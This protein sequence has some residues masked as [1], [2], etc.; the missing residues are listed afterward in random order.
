MPAVTVS[1]VAAIELPPTLSRP[2]FSL[3]TVL[4]FP[5][6]PGMMF[7]AIDSEPPLTTSDPVL[8]QSATIASPVSLTMPEPLTTNDEPLLLVPSE[9]ATC[10][11]PIVSE[12]PD[13]V[14]V[15]APPP[16][17]SEFPVE[18][19]KSPTTNRA[20]ETAPPDWL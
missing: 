15:L 14:A 1:C 16:P 12:P 11:S 5:F 19:K 17:A 4:L 3:T 18:L 13:M 9:T 10:S 6:S 7:P 8:P 20:E 2:P